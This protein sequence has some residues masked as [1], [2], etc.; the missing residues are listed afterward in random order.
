M[1]P[2]ASTETS[3]EPVIRTSSSHPAAG[4]LRRHRSRRHRASWPSPAASSGRSRPEAAR[5]T[6][7]PTSSRTA[8]CGGDYSS[9]SASTWSSTCRPRRSLTVLLVR[10]RGAAWATTGAVVM[11]IGTALYAVGGA[12]WAAAYYFATAPGRRSERDRP[13]QRRHGSPVRRDDPGR[14]ARCR[15]HRYPGGRAL[16]LARRT[17]L[18]PAAVAHHR[19]HVPRPGERRRRAHHRRTDDGGL[20]R[21]GVLRVAPDA[22]KR[23]RR[24]AWSPSRPRRPRGWLG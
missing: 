2:K 16:A 13:G 14:A 17:A 7:T 9:S 6:R 10:A 15:R 1:S 12:G 3:A 11:W 18:D 8:T 4:R 20:P 21:Y 22:L 5:P 23:D 24:T 19:G